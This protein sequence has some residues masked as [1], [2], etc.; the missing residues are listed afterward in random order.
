M[1]RA[2]DVTFG[3]CH[4]IFS[5]RSINRAYCLGGFYRNDIGDIRVYPAR[6]EQLFASDLDISDIAVSQV[7]NTTVNT[8]SAVLLLLA[9][10]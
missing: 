10:F 7:V 2:C 6:F 9:V 4:D 3:Q 5:L 8:F 1:A